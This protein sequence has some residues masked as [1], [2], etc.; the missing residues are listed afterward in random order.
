MDNFTYLDDDL[1]DRAIISSSR[2]ELTENEQTE[3]RRN[4]RSQSTARS[5]EASNQSDTSGTGVVPPVNDT[6]RDTQQ[7]EGEEEEMSDETVMYGARHVI[8]L[9]V[10]VSICML[11][12]VISINTIN[13]YSKGTYLVYTPFEQDDTT[14][15]ASKIWGALANAAIVL[16]VVI[17]MTGLL[18]LLYKYRCYKII[19]GWL[20]LASLL[21]LFIFSY[22]QLGNVLS[23]YNIPMDYLTAS[24]I[25]WNFGMV[26]LV[27]IHWKGPLHL[28]QAYLIIVS[29]LVAVNF[30]RYLPDWTTW[31]VLAFISVWDLIAVLC[32]N[33]PLRILVELAHERN[34]PLF[35]ALIYSSTMA[36]MVGMADSEEINQQDHQGGKTKGKK[37]SAKKSSEA[38]TSS[39][40]TNNPDNQTNQNSALTSRHTAS[41][42]NSRT[43][44]ESDSSAANCTIE[45]GRMR[46]GNSNDA[47]SAVAALG[48]TTYP[49]VNGATRLAEQDMNG[50]SS[51]A[52]GSVAEVSVQATEAEE[53]RGVKLGLGDFIFYS[54]LVGKASSSGDWNTTIACFV[55]ILIGLCF[56]LILLAMYRKALPALPISITFGLIFYFATSL[57]VRPFMDLCS[58]QQVYI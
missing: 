39:S 37:E 23:A 19:H 12:V 41:Q 3:D 52:S 6:S 27:C 40:R 55:A 8:M 11:V 2:L 16:V 38:A 7:Q 46:R 14:D 5:H 1:D 45:N 26:G 30:I 22:L 35:P 18:I 9:F 48:S 33:G 28:Q 13:N 50:A 57:L 44:N 51:G 21:L 49:S 43:A 24:V 32:P 25:M 54:V 20:V 15:S 10:P 34:E 42:S 56:T 31:V 4:A 29:A 36:W 53:E 58:S 17:V 47:R